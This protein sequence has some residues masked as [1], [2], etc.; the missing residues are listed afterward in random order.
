MYY[1][2]YFS[3]VILRLFFSDGIPFAE[4]KKAIHSETCPKS[5]SKSTFR[6]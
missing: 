3:D 5:S 1:D 4:I 2:A 6:L